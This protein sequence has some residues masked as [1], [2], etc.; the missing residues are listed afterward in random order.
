MT[1]LPDAHSAKLLAESLITQKLAAC[2]NILGACQSIY[3]WQDKLEC[4]N[5]VPLLI[6]TQKNLYSAVE[7]AIVKTHP[8][9]LPEIIAIHIDGGLP[10]YLQWVDTQLSTQ[11]FTC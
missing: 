6:K 1:T 8:Y 5:E 7:K 11:G 10:A 3:H 4:T 9:E 2:V